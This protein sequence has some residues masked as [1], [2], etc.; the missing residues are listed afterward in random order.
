VERAEEALRALG[1]DELR[2]RDHGD[3]ARVEVPR[4]LIA[5]AAEL[6]DEI[7]SALKELGY[8]YVALDLTGF[9]SGAMNEVLR[10]PSIRAR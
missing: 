2:V 3:L 1:F 10:P 6:S 5:R 4:A 7:S 8:V 9:R